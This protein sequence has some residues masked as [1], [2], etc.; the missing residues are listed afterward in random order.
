MSATSAAVKPRA[1]GA[2]SAAGSNTAGTAKRLQ[3]E[4]MTL[5]V[6]S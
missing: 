1:T 5:M 4:L 3:T 2:A 6:R